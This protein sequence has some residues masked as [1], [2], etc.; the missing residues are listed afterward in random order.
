LSAAPGLIE[1]TRYSLPNGRRSTETIERP[2]PIAE[3]ASAIVAAGYRF[4]CEMLGDGTVSLTIAD[5]NADHAIE[6]CP[7]GPG[8][9]AAVERLITGFKIPA[10]RARRAA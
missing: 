2:A 5:D 10:K 3:L 8:I 6:L 7:N 1:F 9:P 4:E